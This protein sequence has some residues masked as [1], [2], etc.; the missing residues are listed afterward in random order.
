[1]ESRNFLTTLLTLL[2]FL[3][4]YINFILYDIY[5]KEIDFVDNIIEHPFISS[6]KIIF[7]GGFYCLIAAFI[8]LLSPPFSHI[9]VL[10]ALNLSNYYMLLSSNINCFL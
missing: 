9:I 10:V 3:S 1:M 6:F 7:Y 2:V 5:H 8:C 4:C